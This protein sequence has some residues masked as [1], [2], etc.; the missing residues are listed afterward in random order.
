PSRRHATKGG[1]M[2]RRPRVLYLAFFFPPSRASGVFRPLATANHLAASGWDV[3]VHTGPVRYFT[4]FLGSVDTSLES[5]VD[6]RIRV[7]RPDMTLP[8][9][10]P[11][12]RD[13]GV[14]RAHFP[15]VYSKVK[16]FTDARG[17]PE[18]Y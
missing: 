2:K 14:F 13:Y 8:G 7:V 18:Q 15:T 3:T 9:A 11:D 16:K 17:F 4:D 6:P 10:T 12:I 1:R 5:R